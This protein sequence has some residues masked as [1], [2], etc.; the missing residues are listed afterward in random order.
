MKK[1][2]IWKKFLVVLMA[3]FSLTLLSPEI[4]EQLG[5]VQDVQAAVKISSTKVTLIKGQKKTLKITGTGKNP[6]WTSN[7]KSVASVSSKGVITAK[8]KGTAVITAK[9]GSQKYTCK[10]TVEDP[11]LSTTSMYLCI[12]DKYNLKLTGTKQKVTWSSDKKSIAT[13]SNKG[14]VKSAGKIIVV[15]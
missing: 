14:V 8:K 4:V 1:N 11:K 5:I 9:V 10:I 15:K 12:G 6:S 13:V 7:N 3:V 2:R